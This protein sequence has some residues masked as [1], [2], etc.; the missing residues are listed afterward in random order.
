[1]GRVL[2]RGH[3]AY[4]LVESVEKP[5]DNRLVSLLRCGAMDADSFGNDQPVVGPAHFPTPPSV[6][7]GPRLVRRKYPVPVLRAGTG[8][9]RQDLIPDKGGTTKGTE[10][11]SGCPTAWNR[12][13]HGLRMA[14]QAF[15]RQKSGPQ[16]EYC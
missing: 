10:V 3:A 7:L 12:A 1:M 13:R 6:R 8:L 4:I 9:S 5:T 11:A 15:R 16:L 2:H 14:D